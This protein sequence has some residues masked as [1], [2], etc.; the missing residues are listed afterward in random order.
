MYFMTLYN[1]VNKY[2]VRIRKGNRGSAFRCWQ[3]N[4]K[5]GDSL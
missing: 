4:K 1:M 3:G 5:K 2:P